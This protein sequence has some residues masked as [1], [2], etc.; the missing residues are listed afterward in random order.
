[1]CREIVAASEHTREAA[2]DP[3]SRLAER[4]LLGAE[5]TVEGHRVLDFGGGEIKQVGDVADGGHRHAAVVVLHDVQ[6]GERDRLFGGVAGEEVED[7]VSQVVTEKGHYLPPLVP[8]RP[9]GA[10]A[11]AL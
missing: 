9:E 1:M 3:E 6:R 4:V 2:A 10:L 5:E 11:Q 8:P 7:P